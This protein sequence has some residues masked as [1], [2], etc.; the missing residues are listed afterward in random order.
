MTIPARDEA[1]R[2]GAC[3][4][5]V[6]AA[7]EGRGG[8]VV[9]VNGA[10]DAT[11]DIARDRLSA[12][13]CPGLVLEQ[14]FPPAGGGVGWA[15]RLA[16]RAALDRLAPGGAVMTT[17]A[18]SRVAPDWV[19]ANLFELDR[20]DVICG[21]IL[22]DPEE[23]AALPPVIAGKGRVEG[24]YE[25]LSRRIG[26]LIDPVPHDPHPAHLNAAGASLAFRRGVL[27]LIEMPLLATGEDRAFVR[28]AGAAGLRVRH[29]W[30][31]RVTTSCRLDGRADGG[32]AGALRRRITE[33]DPW[34]D[35]MLMPVEV[36]LRRARTSAELRAGRDQRAY[37]PLWAARETADPA[38]R[39][40][41]M[42]LSDLCRELPRLRV[43]AARLTE[44]EVPA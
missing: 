42:R 43:E 17:D 22:P 20:A 7:L 9:M 31:V 5:S 38:L 2:I 21:T 16:I 4:D 39:A 44:P 25:A 13:G 3:L 1:E 30:R 23:A 6:A 24:E 11:A 14:R 15:R 12:L 33:E 8:V 40:P 26:A 35:E 32:M 19:R 27:D 41:R 10:A 18:D 36:L 34:V 37:G 29:S 28:A